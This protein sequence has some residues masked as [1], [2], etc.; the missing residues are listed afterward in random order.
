MDISLPDTLNQYRR[1]R[2]SSLA[3]RLDIALGPRL[4]GLVLAG[5][6]GR[7]TDTALSDFDLIV[8]VP[9]VPGSPLPLSKLAAPDL[10]LIPL[11]LEHLERLAPFG[12]EQWGYRWTY[13]WLPCL[14]DRTGG[15]I[16]A[17]LDRQQRLSDDEVY[18]ILIDHGRLDEWINL[19]YRTLKSARD[20][21][22]YEARLDAAETLPN[23]LEIV[24]ALERRVRPYNSYLLWSLDH[25][26]LGAW[27]RDAL[28]KTID[29]I[30][31]ADAGTLVDLVRNIRARCAADTDDRLRTTA[32]SEIDSWT[33]DQYAILHGL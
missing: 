30:L 32:V 14:L 28:L 4:L 29:S 20:G 15:R 13:A 12:D 18:S 22:D 7:G 1:D 10:D 25:H 8:V 17:A 31:A 23:F 33:P 27:T 24:F 21:R 3:D 6:T 16:V 11:S 19:V 2:L 5:S 9:D 26:P